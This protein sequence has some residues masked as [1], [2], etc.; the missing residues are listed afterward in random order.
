MSKTKQRQEKE[1]IVI[2]EDSVTQAEKLRYTLEEEGY[3]VTWFLEASGALETLKKNAPSIYITDVLMPGISGFDFCSRMKES[4]QYRYIPVMLLTALSE[5]QDIIRGLECG[6]DS[7]ITKPYNKNYLLSQIDYLLANSRL[8]ET[9]RK[10]AMQMPTMGFDIFFAGRK[11][12]IKSSQ[13]QILDLLFS[14]FEAFVQKNKELEQMNKELVEKNER[15]KALKGLV[16]ICANCKKIRDDD[17]YWQQVDQFLEA[18][19]EA[20]FNLSICPNC[21]SSDKPSNNTE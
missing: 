7:F 15:I 11:H 2:I 19:S 1:E 5:P 9:T 18:H 8:R 14:T 3:N 16:P 6:A 12:H 20:D 13:L 10:N 17:G 4:E 21:A